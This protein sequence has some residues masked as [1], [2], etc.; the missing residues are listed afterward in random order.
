MQRQYTFCAFAE[1]DLRPSCG[2]KVALLASSS[3][4]QVAIA[5]RTA[6]DSVTL[7][8]PCELGRF[9]RLGIPDTRIGGRSE[10]QQE[11]TA[12]CVDAPFPPFTSPNSTEWHGSILES[13]N[14]PAPF[15]LVLQAFGSTQVDW[16]DTWGQSWPHLHCLGVASREYRQDPDHQTDEDVLVANKVKVWLK[17]STVLVNIKRRSFAHFDISMLDLVSTFSAFAPNSAGRYR[18]RAALTVQAINQTGPF[19]AE[20]AKLSDNPPPL[21]RD[22]RT[23]PSTRREWDAV[24]TLKGMFASQGSDKT[25]HDYHYLYGS[26]LSDNETIDSIFEIGLGT[27]NTDVVSTMGDQGRPGAS[28]RAF[29]DFCPNAR[30]Y[31]ADID[32]RVLFSEDRIDTFFVDQTDPT[33]FDDIYREIPVE[34]DLVIDDGLHSPN[35]NIAS[36][37]F[38]LKLVKPGG[39]VVIEDIASQARCLWEVVAALLPANKYEPHIL[40]ANGII[41]FAVH[42]AARQA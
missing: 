35:A 17:K 30:V 1:S 38:A 19:L 23:F 34:F 36:L 42:R 8:L 15:Q 3:T 5:H 24:E 29:R 32:R 2:T 16:N 10:D 7:A 39:W 6:F 12:L 25:G 9:D 27:N 21:V 28:L 31:G 18:S 37:N 22:I 13:K 4:N 41:V 20:L 40:D 26:I 14:H 33:T 11:V